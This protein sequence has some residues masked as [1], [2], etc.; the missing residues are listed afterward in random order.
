MRPIMNRPW[1]EKDWTF[2]AVVGGSGFYAQQEVLDLLNVLTAVNDPLDGVSLAGALRSPFFSISDDALYW[3]ATDRKG[4]PHEGLN[5]RDE[6][7]LDKLPEAGPASRLRA[8]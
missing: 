2:N 6:S 4:L 5:L 8:A 3:M 7:T 1:A